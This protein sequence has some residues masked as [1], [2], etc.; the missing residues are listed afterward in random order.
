M[1]SATPVKDELALAAAEPT[2]LD[3]LRMVVTSG[4]P[5][6]NVGVMER[7]IAMQERKEA[8]EAERAFAVAFHALQTEMPPIQAVEGVPDKQG[9]I[10][11]FFAPYEHIM[12]EVGPLLLKHGFTI[13]FDSEFKDAPNMRL[14][15]RCT[16]THVSGHSRTTTQ[17][18]RVSAPFGASDTQADGAT[19]TMAKRYALCSA[20]NI[21][22]EHDTDARSEGEPISFDKVQTLKELVRETRSDEAR[23][24]KY[25]G[26]A[27][28]EEI[29]ENRYAELFNSLQEK[30]LK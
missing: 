29:G 14:V 18:M 24:L 20:L 19:S 25:A 22:I 1:K 23:F 30:L 2:T 28:Y 26:A 13:S 15:M 10:K 17:Y 8:K 7:L 11:Y 4:D 21:V 6:K 3:L 27:T 12:A 5:E 16:M 9:N